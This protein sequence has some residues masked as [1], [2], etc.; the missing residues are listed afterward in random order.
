MIRR[1]GLVCWLFLAF[2]VTVEGQSPGAAQP[3][4]APVPSSQVTPQQKPVV[5]HTKV[6]WPMVGVCAGSII[7][8]VQ[9]SYNV[10]QRS[11][12]GSELNSWLFGRRPSRA[13]Y[14]V[15]NAAIDGTEAFISYKLLHSRRKFFRVAGWT[16]LAGQIA[17]H[18]SGAIYN[19][20][21]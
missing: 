13:R 18:V 17:G 15:T 8:D 11:P 19:A 12:K 7:A 2:A 9:T 3:P 6:F 16:L 14:Y 5:F 4:D 21:Q 20:R 1:L 10:E